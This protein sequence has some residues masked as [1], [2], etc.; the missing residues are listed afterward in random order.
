METTIIL[1]LALV[2]DLTLGEFPGA[3][4]PVMWMGHLITLELKLAP[5]TG[6]RMQFAYSISITL[7]TI[8]LFFAAAY[9]LLAYLRGT[10]TILYIVVAALLLKSSFAIK[11]LRAAAIRIKKLLK[12][13][14][15]QARTEMRALVK[16][17]TT[18][19]DETHVV[20]ATIESIA[21]NTADSIVAPLF[22]FLFLGVPG[23]LAYRVVNTLDARIGYHGEFEYL[24]KFA[25]RLDDVL[26]FIPSRLSGL[27]LVAAAYLFRQDGDSAWQTMQ[28]DHSRTASPNAGW[29]MSAM[30]G[31]LNIKLEKIGHY[32]L[33]VGRAPL[34]A[35][36]IPR[37]IRLVDIAVLL[38][39]AFCIAAEVILAVTT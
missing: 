1:V 16:R 2:I 32:A 3:L 37:G 30:A 12:T 28:R 11:E 22:Y 36:V 15:N 10:N 38:W 20:S 21:E 34:S 8:A 33:G 39:A 17:D 31:A 6:R 9:F 23:A 4:H 24:G 35:D 25:A 26:N 13:N 19:L 7:L 27:L 5:R 29:P 18:Q 14:L